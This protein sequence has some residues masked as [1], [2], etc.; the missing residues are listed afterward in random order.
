MTI[1]NSID[2]ICET[3]QKDDFLPKDS[4]NLVR[5]ALINNVINKELSYDL[6]GDQCF[7][8]I[9][10]EAYLLKYAYTDSNVNSIINRVYYDIREQSNGAT[11]LSRILVKTHIYQ[12]FL[13][14]NMLDNNIKYVTMR[15]KIKI[16]P[17]L[18]LDKETIDVLALCESKFDNVPY[19]LVR[20]G[21]IVE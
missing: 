4:A 20:K 12:K 15:G 1:Q 11:F 10:G 6:L 14:D 7:N 8:L 16:I 19:Q 21:F 9:L 5:R 13:S 3:V 18:R 17:E 2:L